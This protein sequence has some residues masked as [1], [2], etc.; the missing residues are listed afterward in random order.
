MKYDIYTDTDV[1]DALENAHKRRK[2][3]EAAR[4]ELKYQQELRKEAIK[5]ELKFIH[6]MDSYSD[7]EKWRHVFNLLNGYE[8]D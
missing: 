8:N 6:W 1:Q 4:R 5:R 7:E 2:A 3:E